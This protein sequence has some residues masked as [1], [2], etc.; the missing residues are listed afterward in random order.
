MKNEIVTLKKVAFKKDADG[1]TVGKTKSESF[2]FAEKKSVTRSE[3]YAAMQ[4]GVTATAVFVITAL[5]YNNETEIEH[6]GKQYTVIR[7]YQPPGNDIELVCSDKDV[8]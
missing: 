8:S 3:F 5:D 1:Y 6:N 4:A 7:T 2:V